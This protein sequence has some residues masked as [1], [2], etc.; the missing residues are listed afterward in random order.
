MVMLSPFLRMGNYRAVKKLLT[1]PIF[2]LAKLSYLP[3]FSVLFYFV[4][5]FGFCYCWLLR[6]DFRSVSSKAASRSLCFFVFFLSLID[7]NNLISFHSAEKCFLSFIS[8][9]IFNFIYIR[10]SCHVF[11]LPL[12]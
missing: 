11:F 10:L 7:L 12:T 4:I 2:L 6:T 8:L 9:S 5:Y 1:Y 3:Y